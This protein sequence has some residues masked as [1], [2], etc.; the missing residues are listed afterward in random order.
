MD[1]IFGLS[2]TNFGLLLEFISFVLLFFFGGFSF[3]VNQYT[4]DKITTLNWICR[5]LGFV[6]LVAGLTIQWYI[7]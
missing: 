1:T 5:V 2:Y 3:G 4:A 6:L 7:S